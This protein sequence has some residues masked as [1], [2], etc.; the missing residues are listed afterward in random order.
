MLVENIACG[1]PAISTR[2]VGIPDLIIDGETGLLVEPRN[3]KQLAD[4]IERL[5]KDRKLAEKLAAA[6]RQHILKN[7]EIEIAV[8]PLIDFYRRQLD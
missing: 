5:G 8:Q 1:L 4:A 7:F 6:G 2:L 3:P